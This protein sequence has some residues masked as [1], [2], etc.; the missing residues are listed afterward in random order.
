MKMAGSPCIRFTAEQLDLQNYAA[1]GSPVLAWRRQRRARS[2]LPPLERGGNDAKELPTMQSDHIWTGVPVRAPP[3]GGL[4]KFRHSSSSGHL[5]QKISAS[6]PL[7]PLSALSADIAAFQQ[8]NVPDES[9]GEQLSAMALD[10]AVVDSNKD[11]E[12]LV[13]DTVE[14]EAEALIA[15]PDGLGEQH[16]FAV[17]TLEM[18][19]KQWR[20][21]EPISKAGSSAL[22]LKDVELRRSLHA[23]EMQECSADGDPDSDDIMFVSYM[24]VRV[25]PGEYLVWDPKEEIVDEDLDDE[26]M[27]V[28]AAENA[29]DAG[30]RDFMT[31]MMVDDMEFGDEEEV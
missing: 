9:S 27:A 15:A 24:P 29:V 1:S 31:D 26:D 7:V 4:K 12:K 28:F 16:W 10:L 14:Q 21:Q 8:T 19:V 13:V 11:S 6:Q 17:G 25:Q 30:L 5:Q 22:M 18:Q 23:Q 20:K 2:L 3:V